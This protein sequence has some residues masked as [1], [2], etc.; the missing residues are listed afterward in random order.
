MH[1]KELH[2]WTPLKI[3]TK[4]KPTN[5]IA[6][7]KR[8]EKRDLEILF[9]PKTSREDKNIPGWG[10]NIKM[11]LAHSISNW[12]SEFSLLRKTQMTTFCTTDY[13]TLDHLKS[14]IFLVN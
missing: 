1:I 13:K 6:Q 10:E 3:V 4:I 5:E 9:K 11:N 7:R 14:C 8:I 12:R 2:V